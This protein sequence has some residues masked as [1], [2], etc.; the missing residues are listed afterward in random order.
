MDNKIKILKDDHSAAHPFALSPENSDSTFTC[1]LQLTLALALA[2]ALAR[3]P[4]NFGSTYSVV[5]S[6]SLRAST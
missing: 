4:G 3:F 1:R 6:S 2:R 5:C